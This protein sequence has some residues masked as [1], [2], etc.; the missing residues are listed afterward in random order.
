MSQSVWVTGG[1]GF[2]GTHLVS[3]LSLRNNIVSG[4]G[5]GSCPPELAASRGLVHWMNGGIVGSNLSELERRSGKPSIIFHLAGGSSVGASIASP[6]EDFH[7]TVTATSSL[8]EW[9]RL[10]SPS[11]AIVIASSAAV[12]GEQKTTPIPECSICL[13]NSPYGFHKRA[14]ELVCESYAKT[15]GL[16]LSIVRLFSVYGP[17]LKKQLLWDTC[18]RLRSNPEYLLLEGTGDEARDWLYI[19]DAV[20][21]IESA[22]DF[23]STKPTIV[24]GARGKG[25]TVQE[26]VTMLAEAL[27]TPTKFQFTG[28]RRVGDPHSLVADITKLSSWNITNETDIQEGVKLYAEWFLDNCKN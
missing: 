25:A 3:R 28:N 5:H 14:A 23:A 12:Y 8:C 27:G 2:I 4:I 22:S 13:P 6:T 18:C 1:L 16:K 7:R 20:K 10:S 19:A 26:V 24:N 11:T 9:V 15:Y 21:I 17:G